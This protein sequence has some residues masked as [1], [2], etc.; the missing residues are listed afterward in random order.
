MDDLKML[1]DLGRDLEHEPPASLA[2]QR[3]RMYGRRR[4][5]LSR[6]K[7]WLA[8]GVA[9]AVTASALLVPQ[10][11]LDGDARNLVILDDPGVVRE[12]EPLGDVNILVLGS[13][14]R[15]DRKDRAARSDTIIVAHIPAAGGEA[16]MASIPRDL[17]ADVPEC[18]G[19]DGETVPGSRTRIGEAF[20]AGGAECSRRAVEKLSGITFDH[21]VVFDF[22]AFTKAVD[23]VG[24]VEVEIPVDVGVPGT[25]S[26]LPKGTRTLSGEEALAYVRARRGLGDGSDLARIQRQQEFMAALAEKAE[27]LLR[28]PAKALRL[29][30]AVAPA[31]DAD[32]SLTPGLLMRIADA[33]RRSGGPALDFSTVPYESAPDDR[34]Q[35]IM[36]QPEADRLWRTFR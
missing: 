11:L 4:G 6:P 16:K 12:P 30:K 24:G 3:D 7:G 5:V 18:E 35:I 21:T 33:L 13:D 15:T 17:L 31:L 28:D 19:P 1:R 36:K 23:A 22:R 25:E 32:E 8:L 27:P 34:L 14:R 20:T 9:A 2:R 29:A 26:W 10:L